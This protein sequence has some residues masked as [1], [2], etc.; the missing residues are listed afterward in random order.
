MKRVGFIGV[1]IIGL[2]G[3]FVL[4]GVRN[5]E[6]MHSPDTGMGV[7]TNELTAIE[8][9]TSISSEESS[10]EALDRIGMDEKGTG[11]QPLPKDGRKIIYHANLNVEVKALD[12]VIS[13]IQE[14]TEVLEGYVVESMVQGKNT[15]F[16]RTGHMTVRI[17]QDYLQEFIQFVE[18]ESSKVVES[19]IT[20][21]DVT[22]E[23]VDLQTRLDSKQKVEER[24]LSF[25]EE[26]EKTEDL[27]LISS[28]LARVQEEIEE[29]KGRIQY[30]ENKINL[31]TV[32]IFFQE[33]DVTL[34]GNKN[35]N[36]WDKTKEQFVKS[37]QF[38]ITAFSNLFIFIVGNIPVFIMLGIIGLIIYL[39]VRRKRGRS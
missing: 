2:I 28:D 9:D 1:L 31:A 33:K 32:S 29:I 14:K 7:A 10:E 23:Y 20:G 26:A 8:E 34:A 15:E 37:I 38:L 21:Q 30:L 13:D 16:D 39:V 4:F 24:L 22:E 18:T 3:I 17:P 35:L 6:S 5:E 25:M 27:L 12:E 11:N 19:S 36:I